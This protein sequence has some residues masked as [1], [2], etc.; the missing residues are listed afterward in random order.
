MDEFSEIP[1]LAFHASTIKI[2]GKI[3]ILSGASGRG[4][5]TLYRLFRS[6]GYPVYGD[7]L[8]VV[9]AGT[10]GIWRLFSAVTNTDNLSTLTAQS[11]RDP[12]G[13]MIFLEDHIESGYAIDKCSAMAAA[14]RN[15]VNLR[16]SHDQNN[17]AR[18]IKKTFRWVCAFSRSV[19]SA[20]LNFSLDPK[21]P[22]ALEA[23]VSKGLNLEQSSELPY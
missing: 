1:A 19:L 3:V 18:D 17:L 22:A 16:I 9:Y 8:A 4:K 13:F 21:L 23:F 14:I 7:D 5:S 20:T 15:Y 12:V 6:Q 2:R 11:V 10:D